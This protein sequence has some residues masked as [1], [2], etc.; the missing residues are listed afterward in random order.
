LKG[1]KKAGWWYRLLPIVLSVFLLAGVLGLQAPTAAQAEDAATPP[2]LTAD[3]TDNT[4]DNPIEITFE[5]DP[6]WRTVISAVYVD[7]VELDEEKY[8]KD[9]SGKI[10]LSQ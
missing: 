1:N 6:N 8:S 7:N 3:T 10:I 2:E 4:V 5:D 9:T